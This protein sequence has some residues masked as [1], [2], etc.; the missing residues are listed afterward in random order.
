MDNIPIE[1]IYYMVLYAWNKINNKEFIGKSGMEN[2]KNIN[3]VVIELFLKEVSIICKRG[4]Y[5][6]YM[7]QDHTVEYIK[8][9]I[10]IKESIYLIDPKMSCNYDEFSKNNKIN[11]ILKSILTGLYFTENINKVFKKRIRALLLEFH[12]IENIILD[13]KDFH[14]ISYNRLNRDYKFPVELG[15]L[16]YK[17]S[18]PTEE[19]S[20]NTFI[21]IYIDEET[22]SS[23]FEEFLKNFYKIHTDYKISSRN[24]S[25]DIEP[26]EDSNMGLIPLMK[27]DIEIERQEEKIIIDA[28]YYKSA[29]T[30]GYDIK[31]FISNHMY[32]ITAYLRK[33]INTK[34]KRKLRGILIYPSNGYDF[35][36]KFLSKEGYTIEFKT[37]NLNKK[38]DKIEEDLLNIFN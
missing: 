35:Y 27:T 34:E 36:E 3:D 37:V 23:I 15:Y 21:K 16:I 22:M 10:N 38:W 33:N 25:W 18:I 9:K 8:G 20:V 28:K 24:Y 19:E 1:N 30:Y 26:L 14:T 6:E 13:E 32:Q 11:R 29:F 5:G 17:N 2:I 12:H 7:D 4:I 31:R